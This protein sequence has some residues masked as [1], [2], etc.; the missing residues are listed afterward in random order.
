MSNIMFSH[1]NG[2]MWDFP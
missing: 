1:T 2:K